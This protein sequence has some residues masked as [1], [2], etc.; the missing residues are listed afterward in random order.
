MSAI[1]LQSLARQPR[2]RHWVG[3]L[4]GLCLLIQSVLAFLVTPMV[5]HH[6]TEDTRV[7]VVLCTLQGTK[8]V[9]LDMPAFAS[10]EADICPALELNHIAGSTN[11][12]A[13]PAVLAR[14]PLNPP[15]AIDD[16]ISAHRSLHYAAFSSRAPPH[17]V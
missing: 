3:L 12:L 6:E 8:T 14:L 16:P 10:D 2:N 11:L 15:T 1:T 9:T 5:V 13:P 7:T 17:L 4:V